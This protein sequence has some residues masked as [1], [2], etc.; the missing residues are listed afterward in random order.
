MS[1]GMPS[2]PLTWAMRSPVLS[3]A[4]SRLERPT[5]SIT[6]EIQPS[7]AFQSTRVKGERS[8]VSRAMR[9]MNWPGRANLAMASAWMRK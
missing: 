4:S 7:S 5:S 2:G 1:M 9:M 8:E 6:S 3:A